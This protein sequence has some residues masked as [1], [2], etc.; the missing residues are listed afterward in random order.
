MFSLPQEEGFNMTRPL[1]EVE[2]E[3]KKLNAV[4]DTGSRRSYIKSEKVSL[5]H[6]LITVFLEKESS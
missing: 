1:V 5:P 2:I 4:L 6:K 3:G